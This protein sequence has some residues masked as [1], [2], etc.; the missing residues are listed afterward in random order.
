MTRIPTL[1]IGETGSTNSDLLAR[2]QAAALRGDTSF[3][4]CLLVAGRQTAGRGRQGR[5]WYGAHGASLTFSLAW[6]FAASVGLSGLSLAVGVALAD[7]LEPAPADAPTRGA[8]PA[9]IGLKW[10]NDLWLMGDGLAGPGRKLGGVL[11][12][13]TPGGGC[14]IAVIGVGLNVAAQ[15]VPD[16]ASGIAW[17]REI[18]AGATPETVLERLAAPLADALSV[19][20]QAGFAAFAGRFA[21]RDL[22]RGKRVEVDAAGGIDGAAEGVTTQG[23]LLVRTAAGLVTVGSGEA[24]LPLA[25]AG[26]EAQAC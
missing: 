6:P 10:P 16:A 11:I 1:H 15:E 26:T 21:A 23:E 9:R 22:L 7:A 14:R 18:D 19:F 24:R 12:E 17:L 13:T 4:P 2:V 3:S 20:E 5:A 8:A 25:R